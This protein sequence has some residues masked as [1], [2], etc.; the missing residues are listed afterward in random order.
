MRVPS[1]VL[2]TL[3]LFDQLQLFISNTPPPPTE[4][5]VSSPSSARDPPLPSTLGLAPKDDFMAIYGC[6]TR[7]TL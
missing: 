2:P 1:A 3:P 6:I 4:R 7:L 5:P